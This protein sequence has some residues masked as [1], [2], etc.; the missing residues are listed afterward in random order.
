MCNASFMNKLNIVIVGQ[1]LWYKQN[2]TLQT[3]LLDE[4]NRRLGANGT[5]L[6]LC[7][8]APPRCGLTVSL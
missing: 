3:M 6:H 8:I 1:S 4:N 7:H 2:N 5:V